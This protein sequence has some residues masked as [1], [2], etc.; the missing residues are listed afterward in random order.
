M[1]ERTKKQ[2]IY[3]NKDTLEFKTVEALSCDEP[4]DWYVPG[5]G[6]LSIG[7]Q[8]FETMSEVRAAANAVLTQRDE[9]TALLR[10]RVEAM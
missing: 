1:V 9:R 10:K 3:L 8:L 4:S 7:Y 5:E 6:T 2:F